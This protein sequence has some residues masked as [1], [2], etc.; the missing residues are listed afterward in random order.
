LKQTIAAK[1]SAHGVKQYTLEV[2]EAT[3]AGDG[4]VVGQCDGGKSKVIY[5]KGASSTSSSK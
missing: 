2:V 3:Q 4:K 1:L 5:T